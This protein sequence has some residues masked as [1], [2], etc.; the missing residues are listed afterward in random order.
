MSEILYSNFFK[1]TV[2][3]TVLLD[4]IKC[5][6]MISFAHCNKLIYPINFALAEQKK[7]K[8]K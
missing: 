4:K 8:N 7:K 6:S 5:Q 2:N 1:I 3:F